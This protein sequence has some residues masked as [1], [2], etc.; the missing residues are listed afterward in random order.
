MFYVVHMDVYKD[1]AAHGA[2]PSWCLQAGAAPCHSRRLA[3]E[4]VYR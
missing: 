1:Y 2:R 4:E 3:I